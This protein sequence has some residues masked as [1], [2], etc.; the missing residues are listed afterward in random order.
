MNTKNGLI[1]G[2]YYR[3]EKKYKEFR[4]TCETLKLSM[5]AIVNMCIDIWMES[6]VEYKEAKLNI[7]KSKALRPLDKSK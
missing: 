4:K 7:I 3:E 5:S 2:H 6:K 1:D